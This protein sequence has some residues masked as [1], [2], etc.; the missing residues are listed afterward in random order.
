MN[1]YI[2]GIYRHKYIFISRKHITQNLL[3]NEI[4]RAGGS[5]SA[6]PHSESS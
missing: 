4:R 6:S 1:I 2:I 5:D 3:S